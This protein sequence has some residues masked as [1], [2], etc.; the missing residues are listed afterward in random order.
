MRTMKQFTE[1]E[2]KKSYPNIYKALLPRIKALVVP[3]E[4]EFNKVKWLTFESYFTQLKASD[5]TYGDT[6]TMFILKNK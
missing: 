3:L 1:Y 6:I 2:I 4:E 5:G